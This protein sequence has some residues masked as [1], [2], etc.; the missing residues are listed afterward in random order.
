M[1]SLILTAAAAI[2]GFL[3]F[4]GFV[5]GEEESELE[6]ILAKTIIPEIDMDD[7]PLEEALEWFRQ[8][9]LEHADYELKIEKIQLKDLDLDESASSS[10]KV[11]NSGINLRL[12]DCPAIEVIDFIID[13]ARHDYRIRYETI[14]IAPKG[15]FPPQK[16][17]M[18]RPISPFQA[19]RFEVAGVP[20]AEDGEAF[21]EEELSLLG[22]IQQHL[23]EGIALKPVDLLRNDPFFSKQE[24]GE[25]AVI[26]RWNSGHSFLV[27]H[28]GVNEIAS[29]N[30]SLESAEWIHSAMLNSTLQRLEREPPDQ[31]VQAVLK[32]A[33]AP[34]NFAHHSLE[35]TM[36]SQLEAIREKAESKPEFLGATPEEI[37]KQL[38]HINKRMKM[39]ADRYIESLRFH[40]EVLN[41]VPLSDQRLDH[42]GNLAW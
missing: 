4:A 8:Q 6:E 21:G 18:V 38:K 29:I 23:E 26:A 36:L 16:S 9:L 22:L 5:A 14:V 37:E 12:T 1:K 31:R 35:L 33:E 2:G 11:Q 17:L 25:F 40:L 3:G 30:A 28:D 27:V 13:L 20:V 41:E 42:F 39:L 7:V 32:I 19:T 10:I 34:T 15:L 24:K